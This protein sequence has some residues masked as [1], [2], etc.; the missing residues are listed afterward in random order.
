M[1]L[2]RE[3]LHFFL[4]PGKCVFFVYILFVL[5][6][7]TCVRRCMKCISVLYVCTYTNCTSCAMLY[8]Y[9]TH[10]K[11]NMRVAP[12]LGC[13][14]LSAPGPGSLAQVHTGASKHIPIWNA[15][16]DSLNIAMAIKSQDVDEVIIVDT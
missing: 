4:I 6:F 5:H 1:A 15:E 11:V 8:V 2:H 7:Q 3:I 13:S 10:I 14:Q 12:Q 16:C 9:N